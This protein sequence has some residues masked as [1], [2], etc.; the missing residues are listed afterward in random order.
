MGQGSL[1]GRFKPLRDEGPPPDDAFYREEVQLALRNRGMPLEPLRYAVTPTGLHYLLTH[2]DIPYVDEKAWRLRIDGLVRIP[3][4]LD[5]QTLRALP[6]RTHTVTME[7]AGN[8]RALMQ[9]RPISQPWL[10][11]AIGTAEWTGAPLRAVLAD[12]GVD[13]DAVEVVFTGLDRGVQGE[14]VQ[15]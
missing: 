15:D 11:E 2:F 9:P 5:L 14:E 1:A 13:P 10:V 7:C 8:G 12:A 6:A 3:L 4:E